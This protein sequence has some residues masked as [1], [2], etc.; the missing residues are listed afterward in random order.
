[1]ELLKKIKLNKISIGIIGLG[2]VSLPL[3]KDFAVKFKGNRFDI[4]KIKLPN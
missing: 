4:D 3:L 2:Y 1:M